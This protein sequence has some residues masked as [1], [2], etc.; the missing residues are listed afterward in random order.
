[1]KVVGI[2]R[3]EDF[4]R[5]H[6]DAKP[7]ISAWISEV[8]AAQWQTPHDV[9]ERYPSVSFLADNV[10]VFNIKG[11]HYRLVVKISYNVQVVLIQRIGTHSEYSKWNLKGD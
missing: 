3:L 2:G 4:F 9:K 11:N 5:R 1:M 8:K 7:Q 6:A 10:V